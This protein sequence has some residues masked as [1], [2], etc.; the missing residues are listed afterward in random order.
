MGIILDIQ[1]YAHG[2]GIRFKGKGVR[3]VAG[4]ENSCNA[5]IEWG[6]DVV[7]GYS[8]VRLHP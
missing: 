2:F 1:V 4:L 3:G 5:G 6:P 8:Y 7:I